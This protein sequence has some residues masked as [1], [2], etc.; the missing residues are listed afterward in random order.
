LSDVIATAG[1]LMA[2]TSTSTAEVTRFDS[3]RKS[4]LLQVDVSKPTDLAL[5]MQ[6][7]DLVRVRKLAGPIE[8]HVR[9]SGFVRY[10]GNYE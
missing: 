9:V 4:V 6:D 7:G 10:P 1:G 8:N 3:N 2:S 5:H